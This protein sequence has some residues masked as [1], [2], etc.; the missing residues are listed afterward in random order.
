MIGG[1]QPANPLPDCLVVMY[2][3][4]RP[5]PA[6][7]DP[8]LP[9]MSI[10]RFEAQLDRLE[11]SRTI[12]NPDIYFDYLQS[13]ANLPD[14]SALLTFDDGLIDHVSYVFPVLKRRG[15]SGLFLVQTDAVENRR[16]AGAHM[17]HLLLGMLEFDELVAEFE[18]LLAGHAPGRNLADFSDRRR[19]LDLYYYETEPR[20]LYK[21]AVAF[22]LPIELRDRVLTEL[23]RRHVGEP[24]DWARR[25]YPSW[26]QLA[27]VQDAGMHIGGHSHRHDAYTRLGPA[28]RAEDAATCWRILT[29]RLG[30]RRRAFGYP[31]GRYDSETVHAVR[32]AGFSASLTTTGRTNAGRVSP[33][34]IAR[35]DCIRLDLYLQDDRTERSNARA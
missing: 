12:I 9:A 32:S 5:A 31:Y 34:H 23:F 17:N 24:A 29:E 15:L 10:E 16:M 33:F 19:A 25:F 30:N 13:R 8:A 21:Y 1:A 20:A 2:H 22:G 35:V 7:G 6:T 28:Q 26:E 4:V 3:Y 27:R 14:R 18:S 11:A